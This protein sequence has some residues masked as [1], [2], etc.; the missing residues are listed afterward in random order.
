MKFMS[1]HGLGLRGRLFAAE[2]VFSQGAADERREHAVFGDVRKSVGELAGK[3]QR[4]F[5]VGLTCT[6]PVEPSQECV[7][8]HELLA[9]IR[10]FRE[11]FP[12][13]F[14][15]HSCRLDFFHTSGSL[16]VLGGLTLVERP[17]PREDAKVV[18]G[19]SVL[20]ARS[21]Q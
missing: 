19:A 13:S 3:A 9:I 16:C 4:A 18:R 21:G 10:H 20:P 11:F 1:W 2:Q 5:Q 8:V 7:D 14:E 12:K 17:Q 6:A 15:H